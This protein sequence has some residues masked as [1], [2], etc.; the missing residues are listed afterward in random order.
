M[1]DSLGLQQSATTEVSTRPLRESAEEK[2]LVEFVSVVLADTEETWTTLFRQQGRELCGA[3][4]RAVSRCGA[5]RLRNGA[6]GDGAILL[7]A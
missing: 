6:V 7:P 5:I 3:P 4:P 2:E 1:L